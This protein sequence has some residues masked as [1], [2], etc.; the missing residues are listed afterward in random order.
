MLRSLS[1][2][3]RFTALLSMLSSGYGLAQRQTPV[4]ARTTPVQTAE[5]RY[6]TPADKVLISLSEGAS[7]GFGFDIRV[8]AIQGGCDELCDGAELRRLCECACV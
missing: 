7:E 2:G 5:P 1:R 6:K 8:S 3:V 4:P